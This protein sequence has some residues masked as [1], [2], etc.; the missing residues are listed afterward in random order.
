MGR[1]GFSVNS[2]D[3]LD[4]LASEVMKDMTELV[5]KV[6]SAVK[7][8]ASTKSAISTSTEYQLAE[9]VKQ[10]EK[11]AISISTSREGIEAAASSVVKELLLGENG[12]VKKLNDLFLLYQHHSRQS[13]TWVKVV[14]DRHEKMFSAMDYIL[15]SGAICGLVA[16]VVAG[17]IVKLL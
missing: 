9:S 8:L 11:L 12:P 4:F 3:K 7:T 5:A 17:A 2:Q 1:I 6:E 14:E 15:I 16:G 10:I 13:M